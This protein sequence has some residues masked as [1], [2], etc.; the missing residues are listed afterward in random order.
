[1]NKFLKILV[2][3]IPIILMLILIPLTKNDYLLS[4]IYIIIIALSFMIKYEKKDYLFLILGLIVML[5]G[6]FFFIKTNVETFN[7]NTLF[8]MMPL[9]LPFLW[10]YVFVAMKRIIRILN[11]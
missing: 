6:E 11:F 10:A 4:L 5:V 2:N 1:M 7:R 9:W 3:L 8:N